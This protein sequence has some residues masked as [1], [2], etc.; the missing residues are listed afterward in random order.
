MPWYAYLID[1]IHSLMV[2][3]TKPLLVALD[4]RSGVGKSTI[5]QAMAVNVNS[6]IQSAHVSTMAS[7]ALETHDQKNPE[8][9]DAAIQVLD[10]FPL[11]QEQNNKIVAILQNVAPDSVEQAPS[12]ITQVLNP[13]TSFTNVN[14]GVVRQPRMSFEGKWFCLLVR[15]L[16][17]T[18]SETLG[19][20]FGFD[21]LVIG[22]F[23]LA[24]F[25]IFS[26]TLS[27]QQR[28]A[29]GRLKFEATS[30]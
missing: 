25:D 7:L 24:C 3:C 27:S 23:S 14:A 21:P 10:Q 5:A 29:G 28:C 9:L 30:S 12:L 15:N 1:K 17:R 8:F 18:Y 16:S 4:G 6:L 20:E 13:I 19:G 11:T 22:G 2:G 26:S